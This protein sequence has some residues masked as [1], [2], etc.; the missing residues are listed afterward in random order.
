LAPGVF[1]IYGVSFLGNSITLASPWS[2]FLKEVDAKLSC[3]VSL[4]C[5]GGF[6]LA[7]QYGIPRYTGDID[8][9]EVMPREAL[10]EVEAVA[11]RDSALARKYRLYFQ[12][13]GGIVDLPEEYG[14]R[15][16]EL[17]L[18]LQK[19]SL[20]ALEPYDLLLSKITRNS[21]KDREDARFLIQKLKLTYAIF[22]ARWQQEMAPSVGNRDRHE[23]TVQLWKEYFPV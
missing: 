10:G 17:D 8:Y 13:I 6:V 12:M 2:D 5:V 4:T 14:S 23:L 15:V 1:A 16:T 18:K 9:I 7:A 20:L 22:Y 11:G 19:L 3:K 21:P